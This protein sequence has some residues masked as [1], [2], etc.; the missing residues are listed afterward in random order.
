[1][2]TTA[3]GSR[4]RRPVAALVAAFLALGGIGTAAG[5]ALGAVGTASADTHHGDGRH[6]LGPDRG[7]RPGDR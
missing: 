4:A 3:T 2:V 5:M 7:L 6:H 1:M